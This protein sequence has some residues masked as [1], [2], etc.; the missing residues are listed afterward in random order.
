MPQR[1]GAPLCH[2]LLQGQAAGLRP[3]P[4]PAQEGGQARGGPGGPLLAAGNTFVRS[5]LIFVHHLAT[6][7]NVL[8]LN[9]IKLNFKIHS[10][11]VVL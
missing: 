8:L 3:P 1:Q 6:I 10:G 5:F 2:L 9:L 11:S 4:A 7:S